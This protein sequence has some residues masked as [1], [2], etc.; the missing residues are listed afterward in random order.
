MEDEIE[1]ALHRKVQLKSG[2]YLI[3]EQTEAMITIDVNT[4][5]FVGY[6]NLEDTIFKTNLEAASA[7]ARQLRLRNLGGIVII[8]FIDMKETEHKRKVLR[9][10]EKALE[11]DHAKTHISEVSSLGLVQMTRKRSSESLEHVLC[12]SCP[13][14]SSR[15][16]VKTAQTICYEIFRELYRNARAYE[17]QKY[18]VLATQEVVDRMLDEEASHL[19]ELE[20]TIGKPIRFQAER[21]YTQEQFDVVL[22]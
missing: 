17:A 18:L 2:G 9:T 20:A 16:S 10:L 7:L 13:T 12:E 15:G 3:I 6:R 14:C 1:K 22:L 11:R 19:A 5:A 4:G 21:L 8:D